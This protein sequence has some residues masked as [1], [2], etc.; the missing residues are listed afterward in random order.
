MHLKHVLTQLGLFLEENFCRLALAGILAHAGLHGLFFRTNCALDNLW[1]L[2]CPLH[3]LPQL[4]LVGE[5]HKAASFFTEWTLQNISV[6]SVLRCHMSR[7]MVLSF[8]RVGTFGAREGPRL[9]M[10]RLLV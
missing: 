8:E 10:H 6:L 9:F 1:L 3:V 7:Q 2:M 4:V 5:R